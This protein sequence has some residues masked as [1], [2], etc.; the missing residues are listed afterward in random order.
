MKPV[1]Y[2]KAHP[3]ITL[4]LLIIMAT[5][6]VAIYIGIRTRQSTVVAI[7]ASAQAEHEEALKAIGAADELRKQKEELEKQLA[8]T[9]QVNQRLEQELSDAKANSEA[10]RKVYVT[11]AAP[12]HTPVDSGTST[13]SLCTR[14]KQ[15][16]LPC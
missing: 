6:A 2:A 8:V 14:A 11:P 3:R 5:L 15:L 1:E 4:A 9:I 16:G 7:P 12:H 10:A 13:D